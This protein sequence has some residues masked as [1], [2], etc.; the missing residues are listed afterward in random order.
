[1]DAGNT[2]AIVT[3]IAFL[4]VLPI[5]LFLEGPILQV[6]TTTLHA[7]HRAHT[8]A[9]TVTVIGRRCSSR[10]AVSWRGGVVA[11]W[12]GGGATRTRLPHARA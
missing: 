10:E 1:M 11:R 5:A 8:V 9:V 7:Q 4:S 2:F 6:R 3:A 12:G